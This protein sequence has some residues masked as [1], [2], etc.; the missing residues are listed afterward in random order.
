MPI[1]P[2][3]FRGHAGHGSVAGTIGRMASAELLG[4]DRELERVTSF[5]D[6]RGPWPRALVLHGEAG[7]GKTTV[8]Q[9]A[10]D[11]AAVRRWRVVVTRPTEAEARVPF[12]GLNDLVGALDV[13]AADLPAPQRSA[14]DVALMRTA[15]TDEPT[16]PLALSLAVLEVL[17]LSSASQPLLLG[18]DDAQWL[19]ESTA[20]VVAFALR[21]LE[22]AH[23]IVVVAERT[24]DTGEESVVVRDL[25]ADRID[26]VPI[27]A[28]GV[29]VTDR[30]LDLA[31]GLRLPP[32]TLRSVHERSGGN[33]LHLLELGR[34]LKERGIDAGSIAELVGARVSMLPPEAREVLVAMS[35]LAH[36]TPATARGGPRP[37]GRPR[38]IGGCAPSRRHRGR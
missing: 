9:A 3:T 26:R 14:L 6:D 7:I 38:G 19:D 13:G 20:G 30:L 25:P 4:R 5:L 23:V 11:A 8:W 1:P 10:L 16:P 28:L 22:G 33:P 36:P 29:E 18:I 27:G 17:R 32:T 37:P 21:R 31:L 15:P 24:T 35:A 2:G 12:A 34:A